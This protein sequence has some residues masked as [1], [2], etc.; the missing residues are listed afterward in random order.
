[1]TKVRSQATARE[2]LS[3]VE[4][5]SKLAAHRGRSPKWLPTDELSKQIHSESKRASPIKLAVRDLSR[6]RWT[7]PQ[8]SCS[9]RGQRARSNPTSG[10]PPTSAVQKDNHSPVQKIRPR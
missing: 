5:P 6:R 3:R 1:M 9:E 7:D 2:L 8:D 4:R 10:C